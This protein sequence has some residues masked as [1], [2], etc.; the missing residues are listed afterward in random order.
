MHREP[1]ETPMYGLNFQ[2]AVLHSLCCILFLLL[3]GCAS[4][5]ASS[6]T[7]T[8]G[9]STPTATSTMAPT[10]APTPNIPTLSTALLTYKGHSKAVLG[11]AWSP[12]GKEIVSGS[13]DGTVQMWDTKT[14]KQLWNY[15]TGTYVFAVA[16]SPDGKEIASGG[17]DGSVTL[18]NAATGKRIANYGSQ[19]AFIEGL[20][21]SPTV[22]ASLQAARIAPWWFKTH[23]MARCL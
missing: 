14:G 22:N 6:P 17:G 7:G 21:W 11:F 12:D 1:S 15:N 8:A 18:L 3:A 9:T 16:W 2:R 4:S 19:A 10:A 13:D 20:A 23:R 5:T